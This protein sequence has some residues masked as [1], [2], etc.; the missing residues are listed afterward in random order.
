MVRVTARGLSFAAVVV[1]AVLSA[2]LTSATDWSRDWAMLHNDRHGFLIAY[3]IDVFEQ[4]A[5]PA[6]D[7]G[8]SF[9][10]VTARRSSSSARSKTKSR[11]RS[12]PTATT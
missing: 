11:R 6:T 3:P 4:K 8:G 1:V 12:R 9:I 5:D 7:E 2:D 10:R